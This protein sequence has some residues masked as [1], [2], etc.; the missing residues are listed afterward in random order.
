M[1]ILTWLSMLAVAAPVGEAI[2]EDRKVPAEYATINAALDASVPGDTVSVSPGT[3]SDSESRNLPGFG[4]AVSC[5]FLQSGVTLRSTNGPEVTTLDLLEVGVPHGRV[6]VAVGLTIPAAVEGFTIVGA[7]PGNSGVSLNSNAEILV[8]NCV[9]RDLQGGPDRAGGIAATYTDLRVEDC[10]FE[11]CHA[12]TGG[13]IDVLFGRIW[14]VRTV[15]RGCSFRAI[16]LNGT[17]SVMQG[18]VIQDCVFENNWASLGA[19]AIAADDFTPE[20]VLIERCRFVGNVTASQGGG[21]VALQG[22][23]PKTIRDCVFI[24]N[25]SESGYAGA[26]TFGPGPATVTGNTF[27]GNRAA[28]Y[29]AA[30]VI[31]TF[32]QNTL[33]NNII[34]SSSGAPAVYLSSGSVAASC[35]VY[36]ANEDGDVSGFV[37][38]PTDR[39][40][41]PELCDPENGDLTLQTTSPCLPEHSDGCGLIGALGAGCGTVSITPESWGAIK[42]HYR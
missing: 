9:L 14:M 27:W 29:G 38:D 21:A 16:D 32:G 35:N 25:H 23:Y 2:A 4:T 17:G 1:R 34:G 11:D 33:T 39:T 18:A 28:M 42:S 30:V 41:D 36:W 19:G 22:W 37:L 40:I 31:S 6:V 20:G 3:Y 12:S 8:R 13:A 5:A 15:V 26:L 7:P 10:L 24:D